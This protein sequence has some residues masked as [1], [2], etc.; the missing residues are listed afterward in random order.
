MPIP[1]STTSNSFDRDWV[2]GDSI[3]DP[4][5]L[6]DDEKLI[7]ATYTLRLPQAGERPN[8]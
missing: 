1:S 7:P 5:T 2:S 8:L 3:L 4:E 6:F